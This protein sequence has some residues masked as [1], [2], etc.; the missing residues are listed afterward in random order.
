MDGKPTADRR[1]P[2][3]PIV[4]TQDD[5]AGYGAT[6]DALNIWDLSIKWRCD[7]HSFDK[8][9]PHNCPLRPST[10]SILAPQPPATACRSPE[11]WTLRNTSTSCRTGSGRPFGS[12]TGT[13][14]PTSQLVTNQSVEA[15]PGVAGARWY[16]IRSD[17]QPA[18]ATYSIYQQGTYAPGDG[19]H[20]WMG[21]IAQDKKGN[22]AL[23]L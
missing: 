17:R 13:S 6:F 21:S 10:R 23:G 19:V 18:G 3:I 11:S 8:S 7:A 20:R 12:L 1:H 2:A 22:M 5:D 14:R 16:K 15:T 9:R 4:G